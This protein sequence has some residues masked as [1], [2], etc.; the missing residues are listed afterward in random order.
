[1]WKNIKHDRVGKMA[2]RTADE[3]RDGIKRA[4]F[5]LQSKAEIVL[6][7][8]HDPVGLDYWI[9]AWTDFPAGIIAE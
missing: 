3:M 7:F 1:V 2:A 8:F 9:L 6:S 4:V 5:R